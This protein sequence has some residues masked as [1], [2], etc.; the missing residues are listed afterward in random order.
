MYYFEFITYVIAMAKCKIVS[1]I[2]LIC[3][4]KP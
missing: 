3:I 4:D 1:T 2:F